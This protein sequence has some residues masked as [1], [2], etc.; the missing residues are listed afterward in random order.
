MEFDS[1]FKTLLSC[2]LHMLM[3]STFLQVNETGPVNATQLAIGKACNL[4]DHYNLLKE[5]GRFN[6]SNILHIFLEQNVLD[7][8]RV[9][10]SAQVCLDAC[11]LQP[12]V[13]VHA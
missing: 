4:L 10:V 2:D 9:W 11:F 6:N 7:A 5:D 1:L 13:I 3:T 12:A 8:C